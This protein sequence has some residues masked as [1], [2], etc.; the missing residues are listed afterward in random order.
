MLA[1]RSAPRLAALVMLLLCRPALADLMLFPTRIVF[2]KQRA[3]QVELMNQGSTAETYRINLVHRRM[4]PNGEFI[5][6][7][8]PGPGEQFAEPMLRYSPRQVTIPPGGSQIVR[9]LLRKPDGLAEGEYRSHLQ[10]DR[11]AEASGSSSVEDLARRDQKAVGVTIQALVGA[12]IPV[13]VRQ[14]DTHAKLELTDIAVQ[15]PAAGSAAGQLSFQMRREGNR[16][17]YGDLLATFTTTAGVTFE[18]ARAGGVA[19]YTPNAARRVQLPLQMPAG[20]KLPA[21][22]LRVSFKERPESGGKLL[23]EASLNLP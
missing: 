17:V 10:F 18:V 21:G 1:I 19:V 6:I 11:V 23:A 14:G 7:D 5:A 9:I 20:G 22:V 15:P 3:A 4:G 8:S 13:I 2:D 16:S 12:S